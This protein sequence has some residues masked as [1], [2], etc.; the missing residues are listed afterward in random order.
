MDSLNLRELRGGSAAL[1]VLRAGGTYR[2]ALGADLTDNRVRNRRK[3]LEQEAASLG[4]DVRPGLFEV[5]N[6]SDLAAWAEEHPALAVSPLLRGID[7]VAHPFAQ[8]SASNRLTGPWVDAPSRDSVIN[9]VREFVTGSDMVDLHIEGVSG[10]GKTRVVLEAIRGQDFEPLVAYVYAADALP[11]T[12]I[13][14]LQTQSRHTILVV[15][16][17]DAKRHETLAQQLP[18]GSPVK[19]I[20]IGE[21]TGYRP[22]TASVTIEPLDSDA[23][24]RVV[25]ENQPALAAEYAK[26]VVDAS[27]GNVKLALLLADD[28]VKRPSATANDLITSGIIS[29]YV[30]QAL[31]TGREFLACCALALFPYF[32]YD[33]EPS[34]ELETLA[35]AFDLTVTDLRAAVCHLA[36]ADLLSEQGRYRSVSPH[37]LAIY[38]AARGWEVFHHQ[39]VTRLL[40]TL[41][42]SLAERLFQR[43]ADIGDFPTTMDT[44]AQLLALGGLYENVDVWGRSGDVLILHFAALAP[45]A[46]CS[47]VEMVLAGMSDED[48]SDHA[49]NRRT[50]TWVLERLAWRTATFRRAADGLLRIAA[51]TPGPGPDYDSAAH[52]WTDLFGTVVPTTAASPAARI[53]HLGEVATSADRRYRLLAVGAARRAL[54]TNEIVIKWPAMQ[55]GV[56]LERRGSPSTWGD[57]FIYME[58]AMDVLDVLARDDDP[59][60][61]NLATSTL[62][63][64]IHPLLQ[65]DR[66]RSYLSGVV[67]NLPETGL[68]AAR[69]EITRL[70][71]L[72]E[73][74]N[75]DR[76]NDTELRQ[77]GIKI[78]AAQLPLPTPEQTLDSLANIRRGDLAGGE[79]QQRLTAAATAIPIEDR[80]SR[81]L[82]VLDRQPEAAYEIGHTLGELVPGDEDAR[83]R[84]VALAATGDQG[85]LV[86]YLY[87]LVEGG[88]RDA[89]DQLLD[90]DSSGVL[91]DFARLR[92]STR[93]PQSDVGWVRVSA[94]VSRL[95]PGDGAHG[96]FGWH[97]DL[98]P[99]RLRDFLADWLPRIDTPGNYNAVVNFIALAVQSRTEWIV[100]IQRR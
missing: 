95:T 30:T 57:V 7:N 71:A 19:L 53:Q 2:L 17:C 4:I 3:A 13:Q 96:L 26:F 49:R 11:P 46:I 93:G 37:P 65:N 98:N 45:A 29:S 76:D 34:A 40:P 60:V 14:Q 86:G 68:M 25:H 83:E 97:I 5:L 41:D 74:V 87:A 85:A 78:F 44:V 67:A 8:W 47:R 69:T 64:A 94:L 23:L 9:K 24:W 36:K 81:L 91:D 52:S 22:R 70:T 43:A 48:L 63:R 66:L 99:E 38:L 1:D 79:L 58:A 75:G 56:L 82:R 55:V 100:N 72:F 84:L 16:E 18:T 6:A 51:V 73:R 89:F 61:A 62:V 39:I 35:I 20:T 77:Q 15:D 12:L 50:V 80:V 88:A 42:E 92:V 31:P 59:E 33:G 90:S 54:D 21:R 28:I 10:I 27:A 32:G